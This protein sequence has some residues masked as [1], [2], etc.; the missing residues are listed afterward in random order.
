M[1]ITQRF[2]E[3][4]CKV[5]LKAHKLDGKTFDEQFEMLRRTALAYD[6]YAGTP[7]FSRW[8]LANVEALKIR[9]HERWRLR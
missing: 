2:P 4:H 6:S 8:A 9:Q 1:S 7:E 5:R 3:A